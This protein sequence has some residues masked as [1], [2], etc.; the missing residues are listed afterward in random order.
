[1]HVLAL[2]KNDINASCNQVVAAA[3]LTVDEV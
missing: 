1:M 2:V 3:S